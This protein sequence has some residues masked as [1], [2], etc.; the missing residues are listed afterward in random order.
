MTVE[1][2]ARLHASLVFTTLALALLMAAVLLYA[3]WRS[4]GQ[5]ERLGNMARS[6]LWIVQLLVVAECVLGGLLWYAGARPARNEI[7]LIYGVVACATLP[8]VMLY[9]RNS[10][11]RRFVQ[12]AGCLF[13]CAILLRALSTGR[14][15][16]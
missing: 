3:G 6:G 1:R 13:L 11:Q 4:R 8:G 9:S 5:P 15:A 7:H 16:P 12:A 2:I 14:G 10:Q